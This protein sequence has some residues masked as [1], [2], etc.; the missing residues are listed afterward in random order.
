[1]L[2]IRHQIL[3]RNGAYIVREFFG[4]RTPIVFRVPSREAADELVAERKAM[5]L[6]MVSAISVDSREAVYDARYVDNM[7]AG[8]A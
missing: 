2:E 5:L 3:L 4:D 6:E 1:M 8:K 7:R